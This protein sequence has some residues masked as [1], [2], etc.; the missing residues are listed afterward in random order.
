[1]SSRCLVDR[2]LVIV[3]DHERLAAGPLS[4]LVR[5]QLH[6]TETLLDAMGAPRSPS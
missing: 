4:D 1:M 5:A 2:L 6:G 3:A